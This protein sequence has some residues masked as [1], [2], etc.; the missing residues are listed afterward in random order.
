MAA[1]TS[2]HKV[3]RL[4]LH[5]KKNHLPETRLFQIW[6]ISLEFL[7]NIKLYFR[8]KLWRLKIKQKCSFQ[9]H[10]G[11]FKTSIGDMLL[12]G[13]VNPRAPTHTPIPWPLLT[14]FFPVFS[15]FSCFPFCV[16]VFPWLSLPL[17]PSIDVFP[18][19]I[20]PSL[21]LASSVLCLLPL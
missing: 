3:I 5:V 14:S 2:E 13:A 15:A 20:C 4:V 16:C 18:L 9:A 6:A 19:W 12:L 11:L 7:G 21:F 17:P 8:N 1:T 10:K